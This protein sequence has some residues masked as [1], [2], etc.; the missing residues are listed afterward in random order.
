M[1]DNLGAPGHI[2]SFSKGSCPFPSHLL[3]CPSSFSVTK[4]IKSSTLWSSL[5]L[6]S[7]MAA[8]AGYSVGYREGNWVEYWPGGVTIM[9]ETAIALGQDVWLIAKPGV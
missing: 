1:G 2:A 5:S 4:L 7:S 6:D 3:S 8:S 9:N